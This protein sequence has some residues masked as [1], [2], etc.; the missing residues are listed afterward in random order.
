MIYCLF[1][2]ST[3]ISPWTADGFWKP[4]ISTSLAEWFQLNR[5]RNEVL[6]ETRMK[7]RGMGRRFMSSNYRILRAFLIL[8]PRRREGKKWNCKVRRKRK[9]NISKHV[10]NHRI[11]EGGERWKNECVKW[12]KCVCGGGGTEREV[13]LSVVSERGERGGQQVVWFPLLSSP[14]P[15]LPHLFIY[16]WANSSPS[17]LHKDP[18]CLF[19]L[20]LSPLSL[21]PSV[22]TLDSVKK[23]KKL[24][25]LC[26]CVLSFLPSLLLFCVFGSLFF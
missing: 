9:K 11:L 5:D 20:S 23:K 4:S 1:P 2:P 6:N 14:P 15:P 16:C 26:S 13:N 8:S 12:Q 21:P 18:I 25:A 7:R 22:L 10:S 24:L 3:W 17:L 19:C